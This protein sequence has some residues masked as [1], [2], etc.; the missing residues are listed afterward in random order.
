[1]SNHY[2]L[3]L[4]V[5]KA[6]SDGWSMEEVINRWLKLYRGPEIVQRFVLGESLADEELQVVQVLAETWRGRLY[7][8]SWFMSCLNYYIGVP[9]VLPDQLINQI[10]R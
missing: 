7:D 6:R 1:M 9:A 8:I 4:H 2:H 3:V 5:D 10:Y